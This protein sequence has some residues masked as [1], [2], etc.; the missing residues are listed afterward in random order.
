VYRAHRIF[1]IRTDRIDPGEIAAAQLLHF[2]PDQ[3][4]P[5]LCRV[6]FVSRVKC[7]PVEG[8]AVWYLYRDINDPV[9]RDIIGGVKYDVEPFRAGNTFENLVIDFLIELGKNSRDD[10]TAR[11]LPARLD[12]SEEITPTTALE[13]A[14]GPTAGDYS[15]GGIIGET[16][17]LVLRDMLNSDLRYLLLYSFRI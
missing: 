3:P 4:H 16:A 2:S 7:F 15:S 6:L 8:R 11:G 13:E 9:A 5:V 17:A 12:A 10:G 14:E 1:G